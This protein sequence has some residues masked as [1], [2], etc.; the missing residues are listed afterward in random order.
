[1]IYLEMARDEAHGGGTWAFTN[2]VWAPTEKRGGG[3]WPFWSK[4]LHVREGDTIIHLRGVPPKA[5]FVG[6]SIASGTGFETGRR[7]PNPGAWDYAEK[8]YRADLSA[9]TPFHQ[10]INLTEVFSIRQEL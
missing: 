2:C 7:P 9:F 6:Y 5:S 8:F 1:M 3:S 4:V 10:P